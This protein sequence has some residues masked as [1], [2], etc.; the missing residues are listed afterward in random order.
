[1]ATD[2]GFAERTRTCVSYLALDWRQFTQRKRR[3]RVAGMRETPFRVP[4]TALGAPVAYG[5]L[6]AF[7]A[8]PPI[9][10]MASTISKVASTSPSTEKPLMNQKVIG[11][12]LRVLDLDTLERRVRVKTT[13]KIIWQKENPAIRGASS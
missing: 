4:A 11:K 9:D 13:F 12:V 8:A 5:P 10:S 7:I 2:Y 3:R 1:M 6:R